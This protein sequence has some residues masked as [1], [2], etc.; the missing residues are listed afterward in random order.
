MNI[1]DVVGP[2][3]IGP[4]SSHTAGAARLGL[5]AR[6]LLGSPPCRA[7]MTLYGSFAKTY[8]GH[9]TDKA[10]IAG[11]LGLTPD[12]PRLRLAAQL[13][14]ER[15]VEVILHTA[16]DSALHPNTVR[17]AL[18]DDGGHTVQMVG[19]SIGG[20]AIRVSAVNGIPV[21]LGCGQATLLVL[22]RDVPGAI[23]TVTET[24]AANRQNIGGFRLSRQQKGRQAI[25]TIEMDGAVDPQLE[26]QVAALPPVIQAIL[27]QPV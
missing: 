13:A 15:G 23:A 20:G 22:H 18:A 11:V 16:Q 24:V 9:G 5:V 3:M 6:A 10:L 2:V 17:I 26:R 27:L 25:M 4:S 1:F 19:S 7:E 8:Q 21:C 14:R 12:D